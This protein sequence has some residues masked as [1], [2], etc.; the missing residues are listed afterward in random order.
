MQPSSVGEAR[1]LVRDSLASAGR[2]DLVETAELLVS[3]VVTN[4]LLHAG[5]P[6]DLAVFVTDGGLRVEVGDGSRQFPSHR[7]YAPTAGTG[8]G[9][10]LLQQMVDDWGVLPNALGKTVWFQLD[11]GSRMTAPGAT[12]DQGATAASNPREETLAVQLLNVPLLLHAAWQEHAEAML[13][14][15]LL[16]NLDLDAGDDTIRLHAEATDAIAV[17]AKC[18]PRLDIGLDPNGV[19]EDAIGPH[20]SCPRVDMQVPIRSLQNFR[21]LDQTLEAA[22]ALADDV[23][24]LTSPAQPEVRSYRRWLCEQVEQ[25][26][27]GGDPSPWSAADEPSPDTR[28]AA[29]WDP[30]AIDDSPAAVIRPTAPTGS[31]R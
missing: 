3:E 8:R 14:E 9:L 15:H 29:S 26:S 27:N 23:V 17:L 13:R 22:I 24:F 11:S 16:A 5:T 25:Q 7:G 12:M 31:L 6:I 19:M 21:T 28:R 10:M 18:I 30:T 1:R 4:A 2:E 20:A